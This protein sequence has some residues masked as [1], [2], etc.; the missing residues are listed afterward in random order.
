MKRLA[1][2]VALFLILP[3]RAREPAAKARQSAAKTESRP[4]L[5]VRQGRY[6]RWA[7]PR[8]WK[9]SETTNGVTLLSPN[10]QMMAT[11]NI[12]MRSPGMTTPRD[13]I[14]WALSKTPE[15]RDIKV[16]AVEDL[17]DQ[18][19]GLGIP[20]KVQALQLSYAS[21]GA[22]V[23]ATWTA[24]ICAYYGVFDATIVGY[25]APSARWESAKQWLVEVAHSIAITNPAQ[26]AGN[27]A[28]IPARNHPLD[29]SGLMESWR[30]KGLSEDRISKA[31]RE[32]TSGY[33]RLKDPETGRTWELPLESYDGTV[34]GYRNPARPTEIL[35]AT[36]P[37]E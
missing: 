8:G 29:N 11:S 18:P 1:P 32:A 24:G 17:P 10:D 23:R 9:E 35:Q 14:L 12:L 25:Q 34:G 7:A 6:F 22:P 15:Y 5:E 37:G 3:A 2:L 30:Q 33:E 31:R 16:L 36:S 4:P 19:S 21:N 20:W 26:V 27:D 28:L 13:F